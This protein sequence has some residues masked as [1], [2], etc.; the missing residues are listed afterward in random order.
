MFQGSPPRLDHGVRELQLRE[1]EQPAQDTRVDH[2][3]TCAFTFSTPASASTTG[4]VSEG[5]AARLASSSAVT[6]FTGANVSATRHAKLRCVAKSCRSRHG[7][8]RG[9]R[10]AGGSLWCR[11]AR[12]RRLASFERPPSVSPDARGAG[13][14]AS[15]SAVRGG[16]RLRARPRPRRAAVQDGDRAGRDVPVLERGHHVLD[17]PDF[18]WGQSMG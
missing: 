17:R 18:S 13:V 10:R 12:S 15:R 9:S 8:R 6:L 2:S 7:D 1:G 4:A 14:G 3:S 16:T 5:A 11:C